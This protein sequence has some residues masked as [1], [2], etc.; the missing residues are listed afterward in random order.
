LDPLNGPW[1]AKPLFAIFLL[2]EFELLT[3]QNHFFS[4]P[5]PSFSMLSPAEENL[6]KDGN[7]NADLQND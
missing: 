1:R 7:E 5:L 3:E 6:D 2:P 4:V